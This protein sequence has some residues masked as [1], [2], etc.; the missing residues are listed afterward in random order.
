[1]SPQTPRFSMNG[2]G[3]Q[4]KPSQ[5][6]R[7]QPDARKRQVAEALNA[8]YKELNK[9]WEQAEADLKELPIPVDVQI[10]YK[11]VDADSERPGEAQIHYHLGFCRSKGGWRICFD[12]SH[13]NF[14]QYDFDWK[15]ITECSV[16]IRLEAVPHIGTLRDKVLKAA[17]ECVPTLDKAIADLRSTMQSW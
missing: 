11:S 4:S 16:D 1:M 9:L 2:D 3:K 7:T 8:R 15:P 12:T 17:E 6:P 10:V 5:P 14:P 13:D